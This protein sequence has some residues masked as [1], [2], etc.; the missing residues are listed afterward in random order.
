[1]ADFTLSPGIVTN[2][3]DN[4]VRQVVVP[5][6][7]VAGVI[8]RYSW[9]PAMIPTM[10]HS[11]SELALEF[12]KPTSNNYIEWFNGKNFLEYGDN[13]NVVRLID[14]DTA[15]NATFSGSPTLVKNDEDYLDKLIIE[16]GGLSDG[17]GVGSN[18][19]A[20]NAHGSWVARYPGILGNTLK[21]DMCF[22]TE[23]AYNVG[24]ANAGVANLNQLEFESDPEIAGKYKVKFAHNNEIDDPTYFDF[25]NST[26]GYFAEDLTVVEQQKVVSITLQSNTYNLLIESIDTGTKTVN[27]Y[28][29]V[30]NTTAP[31]TTVFDPVNYVT[32]ATVKERSRFREFSVSARRNSPDNLMGMVYFSNNTNILNGVGTVFT[33]QISVG[34]LIT[35]QGQTLRVTEV[36]SNIELKLHANLIGLV[37][38]SSPVPWYRSWRYAELFTGEP[39]TSN[40]IRALNSDPNGNFNDQMHMVVVDNHGQITGTMGEVI[41][42]Y[43]FLSV[44]IDGVDDYGVPT[45][46]V[47][48]VNSNSEWVKWANH[49]INDGINPSNWGS[50]ALSTIFNTYHLNS[51]KTSSTFSGGTNGS[52]VGNDDLIAAIE[53]FK[54]KESWEL[55]FFLTG[56][57]YDLGNPLNYHLAISKM[58]QVAED[59]KDCVVCVSPEYGAT[60]RGESDPQK[61]TD[62]IIQW[63]DAV[64]DSSY[65]IMDGNFKYQYDGYSDTYRWLPLSGDMAGLMAL[66]DLNFKPWYSPAGTTRGSIKNVVKLAYNP[67]P[68]HRDDLYI[69]QINP[70]VTFRGEGTIL[71]GDKTL[72]RIPSAFDRINVRRLFITL[73]EFVIAQARRRLFEFNTPTTRAEFARVAEKYMETVVADQGASD[74]R[75]VCDETNNTDDIIEANRFVADLY[76]KPTYVINFIK[77]NFTAVGQ[78]VDFT[79]LGV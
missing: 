12:G 52:S 3:I 55:D 29:T 62:K 50:S 20:T 72:Q 13:L 8:G 38:S 63:R 25:M 64:Y 15:K 18:F 43:S 59:R 74:F 11:E 17:T 75:V 51:S 16:E 21:V 2:E 71:Y 42:S 5:Q 33:K 76:V 58:I 60:A 35:V 36:V 61:I 66:T 45:Y 54:A 77:L 19:G 57:T 70:V 1:M 14:N 26:T 65:G 7:S 27:A 49:P 37:S 44:A 56:W 31:A 9:G 6:T 23:R 48:R 47:G 78:S 39:A 41:E 30:G 40:S 24:L 68:V 46:Y 69:N 53:L 28:V 34:D 22:A 32:T 67:A 10:V 79:D 4:S 73:K